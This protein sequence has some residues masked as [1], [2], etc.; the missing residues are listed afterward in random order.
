MKCCEKC[1][2]CFNKNSRRK[3]CKQCKYKKCII[4][5]CMNVSCGNKRRNFLM[6]YFCLN[7]NIPDQLCSMCIEELYNHFAEKRKLKL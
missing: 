1:G 3:L 2:E 6:N 7:G 5:G 4:D